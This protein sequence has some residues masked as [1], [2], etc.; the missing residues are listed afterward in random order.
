MRARCRFTAGLLAAAPMF[1]A[2]AAVDPGPSQEPRMEFVPPAAGTYELKRIQSS[3]D[4]TLL[5]ASARPVR[6]AT[7][8]TGRI[9]L[10][11][12]FYTY[13]ADPWGCPFAY[14]T[15]TGLRET[16]LSRRQLAERVRFV[17]VSFDPTH[18]TPEALRRYAQRFGDDPQFDWR[19][20]TAR[21]VPELLP[22]LDAFGQDA[23]VAMDSEGRPTRV[24]NH[25]LKLFLIDR[26]G[27]VR[28]IYSLAFVQPQVMLNDIETLALEEAAKV[29]S[30]R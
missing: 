19:F 29:A 21:S 27:I 6:L 30:S 10:L 11:T 8:T 23:S 16:L 1:I 20:L 28:E 12:F 14:R 15:L 24:V 9:T 2:T 7:Q 13:C 4:A 25:M 18:D 22:L 3:P 5:D 26:E 17:S